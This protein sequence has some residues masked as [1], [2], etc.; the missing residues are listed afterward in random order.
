MQD[1]AH[2]P[3]GATPEGYDGP[4]RSLVLSGGGLRLSYQTGVIRALLE[5]GLSFSHIDATSGGGINLAMLLSGQSPDD[6]AERW[7]TLNIMKTISMLPLEKYIRTR[8]RVALGD[9]DGFRKKVFP[10][11]GID[12]ARINAAS[13]IED[14]EATQ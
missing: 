2:I 4:R 10:H 6:M 12:V 11:L 3:H 5:A 7:R 1:I 14:L 8:D 9:G 13:G